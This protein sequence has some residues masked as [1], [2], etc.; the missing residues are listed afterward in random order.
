MPKQI[1]TII[2]I[3][4]IFFGLGFY[5]NS[6]YKSTITDTYQAG[7]DAAKL[8]LEETGFIMPMTEGMEITSVSGEVQEIKDNKISLKIYPLEPLADPSLDDRIIEVDEN[9]KIYQ[10]VERD[11]AEYQREMAEFN[12]RMQEQMEN[13]E[14]MAELGEYPEPY[15]KQEISLTNI[16]T[17]QQITVLAQEDIKDTKQFKAIEITVQFRPVMSGGEII[18]LEEELTPED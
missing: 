7:W 10:L 5:A 8:R 16:Q 15:T 4:L 3:A 2:I 17:G 13:P 12:Q 6:Y 9:T 1:I 14:T 18:S 11:Q